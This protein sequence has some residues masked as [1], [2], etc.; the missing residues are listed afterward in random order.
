MTG[1][2]PPRATRSAV[3]FTLLEVLAVVLLTAIVLGVALD[4]YVDLS[5]SSIR[6]AAFTRDARRAA[7]LLD[8]MARDLEGVVLFEKPPE[9]DPLAHPWL[10]LG[11][12][13][14]AASG[15]DRLKFV[16]RNHDPRRSGRPESDL[17]LVAYTLAE[18]EEGRLE[19]LR[20]SSPRLPES[21][22]R[23]FPPPDAPGTAL[24]AD[25]LRSFEARFLGEDGEWREEWDSSTLLDSSDLPVAVE[26][27]V[28]LAPEEHEPDEPWEEE[29]LHY[30][31]AVLLPV[32]PIPANLA[33]QEPAPE[34]LAEEE[35]TG[36]TL[37][38][39]V[40]DTSDEQ[41]QQL[42]EVYGSLTELLRQPFEAYEGFI[43]PHLISADCR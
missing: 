12:S 31:R 39:C 28:T 7:A 9:L 26:I 35:G 23:E 25:G 24:L 20:W 40:S 34:D 14:R 16:T 15:S 41:I 18:D 43:P 17:A 36:K 30:R 6:A 29:P 32:R 42:A 37:A 33:S 38:D 10:F 22:D 11:E 8:R 2:G 5:R 4:F 3:G 21:L 19:L 27:D 13:E 1:G